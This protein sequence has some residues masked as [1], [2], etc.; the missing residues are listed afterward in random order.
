[1]D[2]GFVERQTFQ[3]LGVVE[4]CLRLVQG[5]IDLRVV[6]EFDSF[7]VLQGEDALFDGPDALEPPII[8][9]DQGRELGFLRTFG[10]EGFHQGV[11]VGAVLIQIVGRDD[12]SAPG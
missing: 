3:F 2:A 7:A 4:E 10:F 8:I 1:M 6:G 12:D 11:D 9:G 5:C